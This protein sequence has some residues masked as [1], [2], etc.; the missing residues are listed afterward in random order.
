MALLR[1][2]ELFDRSLLSAALAISHHVV[3]SGEDALSLMTS[4]LVRDATGDK[5]STTPLAP[6]GSNV[7]GFA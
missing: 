6:E 7:T 2:E 4:D 1:A 3:V 5:F